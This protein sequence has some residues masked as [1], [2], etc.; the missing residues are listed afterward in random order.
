MT[1]VCVN[2]IQYIHESDNPFKYSC[3]PDTG[4]SKTK[5]SMNEKHAAQPFVQTSIVPNERL[6]EK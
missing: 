3:M 4:L 1:R 5:M 6:H 2:C